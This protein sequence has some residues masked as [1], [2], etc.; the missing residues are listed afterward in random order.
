MWQQILTTLIVTVASAVMAVLGKAASDWSRREKE[1]AEADEDRRAMAEVFQALDIGI[2]KTQVE[3]VDGIKAAA[4]DGKLDGNEIEI[5]V[6]SAKSTALEVLT[7][8]G[9]ALIE[10]M[11]MQA[12]KG[13][14]DWLIQQVKADGRE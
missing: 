3:F 9:L 11:S 6:D 13:V 7:G 5:A 10:D 8:P 12:V 1:K 14:I 2:S 4:A